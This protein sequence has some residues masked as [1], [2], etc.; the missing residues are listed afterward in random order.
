M[1]PGL[2][3]ESGEDIGPVILWRFGWFRDDPELALGMLD[4]GY[5]VLGGGAKG[6]VSVLFLT[7]GSVQLGMTD[8]AELDNRLPLP[9][10]ELSELG[11]PTGC[12]N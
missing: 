11:L 10:D 9:L 4:D 5:G 3:G 1:R 6:V 2:E 7:D 8:T 12:N